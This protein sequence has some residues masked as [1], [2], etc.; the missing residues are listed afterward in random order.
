MQI[1]INPWLLAILTAPPTAVSTDMMVE[2]LIM[3]A[4]GPARAILLAALTVPWS[5]STATRAGV[6]H[7]H[8]QSRKYGLWTNF[9][10]PPLLQDKIMKYNES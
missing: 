6:A 2:F 4:R 9:T 3:A 8:L 10:L 7:R 5:E 1:H